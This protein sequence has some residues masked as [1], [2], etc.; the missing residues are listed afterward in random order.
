M[1]S[2]NTKI[3]R[4]C[5]ALKQSARQFDQ[6]SISIG[7]IPHSESSNQSLDKLDPSFMYFQVL[8]EILLEIKFNQ[9]PIKEFVTYCRDNKC[10]ESN[11]IDRFQQEY[12]CHMPIWWYTLPDF[13]ILSS[14]VCEGGWRKKTETEYKFLS[15]NTSTLSFKS[16]FTKITQN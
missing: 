12:H 14:T 1:S 9:Q 2:I 13:D 6:N 16:Y 8:R 5:Q 15:L 7:V 11:I 10:A 4:I 3:Y